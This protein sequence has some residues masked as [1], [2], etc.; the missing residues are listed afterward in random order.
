[1]TLNEALI[2]MGPELNPSDKIFV[3]DPINKIMYKAEFW[4]LL[5]DPFYEDIRQRPAAFQTDRLFVLL[6][7]QEKQLL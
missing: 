3:W 4:R 1:M 7:S 5:D 6:K 2:K